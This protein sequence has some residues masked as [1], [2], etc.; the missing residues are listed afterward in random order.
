MAVITK[1]SSTL[2]AAKVDCSKVYSSYGAPTLKRAALFTSHVVCDKQVHLHPSISRS[3]YVLKQLRRVQVVAKH[4]RSVRA[5]IASRPTVLVH[6]TWLAIQREFPS[7]DLCFTPE[8]HSFLSADFEY[9]TRSLVTLIALKKHLLQLPTK[10]NYD[11]RHDAAQARKEKLLS[12]PY[13]REAYKHISNEYTPPVHAMKDEQGN[14]VTDPD[15]IDRLLRRTWS[16]IYQG[17]AK[18]VSTH[19]LHYLTKYAPFLYRAATFQL[20]Q[21]TASDVF[22]EV[23]D[24]STSS[25]GMDLWA[26]DD[27]K[28]LPIEAFVYIAEIC[29]LVEQGTPWLRSF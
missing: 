19:I 4:M 22:Q 27:L 11:K 15:S 14:Y 25:L 8:F 17:N 5:C 13:H 2:A 7:Q 28:L 10:L 29:K 18:D 23:H 3:L 6:Q 9:C 20:A 21:I 26:Y 16:A 12:S 1:E 24:S